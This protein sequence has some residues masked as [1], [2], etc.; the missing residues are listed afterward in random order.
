MSN[1]YNHSH[2]KLYYN[3]QSKEKKEE[4]KRLNRLKVKQRKLAD[5]FGLTREVYEKNFSMYLNRKWTERS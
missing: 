4:R 3:I 5:D 1:R 2:I